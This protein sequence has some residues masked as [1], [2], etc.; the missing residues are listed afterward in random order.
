MASTRRYAVF[1]SYRHADNKEPGRQW[2]SWLH[3]AL[4]GYEVP[5][6]LVGTPNNRGEPIPPS[7]YPVF[8]DE[9]E[10][11]ADA[12]LTRN[13]RLALEHS[14]LLVVLCS[15]RA[16]GSRFVADEIR[17][18]KELGKS[19]RI[20]ALMIDGEP[21]ATDDP[22]KAQLGP[23]AE[24]LPEPLRFGV[25]RDDGSID[26]TQRTEPIAAD[27]RP[28]GR[29]VQGWTTGAAY[30]EALVA[31]GL[32]EPQRAEQVRSYEQRLELAKLKVVA[33]ALGVPLGVL[34]Q[35]DKAL[36]LERAR[37]RAR[38]LR[39]WLTAVGLAAVLAIAGGVVA[40]L[41]R[42]EARRQQAAVRDAYSRADAT[43]A[44]ERVGSQQDA[45]AV[46]HLGRALRTDPGNRDAASLLH[47]LLLSR[48]WLRP[49]ARFAP[50]GEA[51]RALDENGTRAA[52]SAGGKLRIWDLADSRVLHE[53][54]QPE[55]VSL[56]LF[57]PGGKY[58]L[59]LRSSEIVRL[60]LATGAR[61]SAPAK[62]WWNDYIFSPDGRLV[63]LTGNNGR[64]SWDIDRHAPVGDEIPRAAGPGPLAV[65]RDQARVL[66]PLGG[67]EVPIWEGGGPITI[68]KLESRQP[69]AVASGTISGPRANGPRIWSVASG[70]PGPPLGD[71]TFA[72]ALPQAVFSA[73]GTRLLAVDHERE[74]R[75]W[76]AATARALTPPLR[77]EADAVAVDWSP[78]G[79]RFLA[80]AGPLVQIWE[81]ERVVPIASRLQAPDD[82]IDAWFAPD[83]RRVVAVA[84]EK[85]GVDVSE[86]QGLYRLGFQP[87]GRMRETWYP[88][89]SV[90]TWDAAAVEPRVQEVRINGWALEALY[91]PNGHWLAI[92]SDR[93]VYLRHV[94]SGRITVLKHP[95]H[96]I[97]LAFAPDSQRLLTVTEEHQ[98][99]V[100]NVE[101]AQPLFAPFQDDLE[102]ATRSDSERGVASIQLASSGHPPRKRLGAFSPDGRLVAL[103]TGFA[104]R[105]LDAQTGQ[106]RSGLWMQKDYLRSVCFSPDGRRVL[107]AGLD[108]FA[109]Q[110]DVAQGRQVEPSFHPNAQAVLALYSA[111]GSRVAIAS[112][113]RVATVWDAT[114][115]A[116]IS[117]E[118]RHAQPIEDLAF[119]PDGRR[120]LTAAGE[121]ARVWDASSGAPLS[122]PMPHRRAIRAAVF[123]PDG[124]LVATA[125]EDQT[126]RLWNAASGLPASV[127]L[128]HTGPVNAVSFSPDGANIATAGDDECVRLWPVSHA[129]APAWLPELAEFLAGCRLDA[130]GN[131]ERVGPRPLDD[132]RRRVEAESAASKGLADWARE[133]LPSDARR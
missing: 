106:T 103:R 108:A 39:R 58:L 1:L 72:T 57:T 71:Y 114:T 98:A 5:A 125:S 13:I 42:E 123:S 115:G 62:A 54:E 19:E 85:S 32:P 95:A 86:R 30:R 74:V 51:I 34:T 124:R 29:P 70:E 22:G 76:D 81:A 118:I 130:A 104:V 78:D 2:A 96:P 80:A 38:G 65:S 6:D 41:Q 44:L 31:E 61:Q 55:G 127:P 8:R 4:E 129:P 66:L 77:L 89:R 17:I 49:Q 35:R 101:T 20:L 112:T 43:A 64:Q 50:P 82:L 67:G 15:P 84:A 113:D 21:N 94:P 75:T 100:W 40:W 128:R 79:R 33:G 7:L 133:A 12:D 48:A 27:A 107:S 97:C 99:Q 90:V 83:G 132:L 68:R 105:L 36:Q 117:P 14:E 69:P 109:R 60:D 121:V 46:A 52:T 10:L 11:P 23:A 56:V 92:T 24:C 110:W 131:Y 126:A 59:A 3:Q 111:D 47:S 53:L 25:A 16:V 119:S 9:E 116:R 88:L 45:E 120:L 73:D 28:E 102:A 26:W 37:A 122:A 93:R 87:R 18:F 63:F 91:S